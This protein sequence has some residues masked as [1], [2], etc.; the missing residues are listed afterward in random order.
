MQAIRVLLA[1]GAEVN[2]RDQMG[3]TPFHY[4]QMIARPDIVELL[5]EHGGTE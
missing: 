4:A 1:A 2:A 5:R 3:N